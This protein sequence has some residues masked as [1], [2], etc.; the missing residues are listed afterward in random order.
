LIPSEIQNPGYTV[1][2]PTQQ[3]HCTCTY[4]AA[5]FHTYLIRFRHSHCNKM[6]Q[7]TLVM[8]MSSYL[9]KS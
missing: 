8:I 6:V 1:H 7:I 9:Y 4:T 3:L 2:V 5:I